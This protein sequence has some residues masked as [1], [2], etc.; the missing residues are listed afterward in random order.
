MFFFLRAAVAG[1]AEVTRENGAL[2]KPKDFKSWTHGQSG[3]SI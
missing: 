1:K 3:V 2:Q